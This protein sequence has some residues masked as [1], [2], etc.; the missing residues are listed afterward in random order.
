MFAVQVDGQTIT[1]EFLRAAGHPELAHMILGAADYDRA[2]FTSDDE[3]TALA[4]LC[5]EA[6]P[7]ST[8]E[9]VEL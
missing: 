8:I 6:L 3:A 7:D 2:E 9:V 4:T 1:R 5:A